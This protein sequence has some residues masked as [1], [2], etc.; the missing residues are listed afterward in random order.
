MSRWP[1]I[2]HIRYYFYLWKVNKHYDSWRKLGSFPV[3]RE[4]DDEV[5]LKIWKGEI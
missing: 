3:H 1:L 5:L 4:L 2:R